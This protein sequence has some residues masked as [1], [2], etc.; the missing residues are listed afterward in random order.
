MSDCMIKEIEKQLNNMRN[1]L[2][3]YSRDLPNEL[4]RESIDF[5]ETHGCYSFTFAR[6]C[7]SFYGKNGNLPTDEEKSKIKE[8]LRMK[9]AR[10][11]IL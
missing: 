6:A 11:E 2:E 1:E 4:A 5:A 9:I 3:K 7:M 8:E 10:G